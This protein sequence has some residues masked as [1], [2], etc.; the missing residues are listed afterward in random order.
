MLGAS[1][2]QLIACEGRR[3][4]EAFVE[5]VEGRDFVFGAALKN[6]RIAITSR[7]IHPSPS[8]DRRSINVGQFTDS[9]WPESNLAGF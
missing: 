6:N 2:E 4:I 8:T 1:K 5:F 9:F 7:Q 3:C